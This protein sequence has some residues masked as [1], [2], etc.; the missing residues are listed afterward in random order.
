MDVWE[1][2]LMDMQSLSKCNDKY[3]YL[4]CNRRLLEISTYRAATVKD[5]YSR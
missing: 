4:E 1:C 2:D 3:K 5:G